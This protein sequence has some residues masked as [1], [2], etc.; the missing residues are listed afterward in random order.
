MLTVFFSDFCFFMDI[1]SDAYVGSIFR[2]ALKELK[3][4]HSVDDDVD[5]ED[6]D[7]DMDDDDMCDDDM[8]GA[9]I[10]GDDMGGGGMD[11]GV[12]DDVKEGNDNMG[13][14]QMARIL[15]AFGA[16]NTVVLHEYLNFIQ[17]TTDPYGSYS[18]IGGCT[19][20][21]PLLWVALA[22][23]QFPRR[24]THQ[25]FLNEMVYS[26]VESCVD[27]KYSAYRVQP[28]GLDWKKADTDI[29]ARTKKTGRKGHTRKNPRKTRK[30]SAT[31][32]P[33]NQLTPM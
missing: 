17:I 5:G 27:R 9:D 14:G 10:H 20:V 24:F 22:N 11:D 30:Q 7:E 18:L 12:D 29:S 6:L 21:I 31:K 16:R 8:D 33:R 15:D 25:K 28:M 32:M 13:G 26:A 1:F 23:V 2:V 3:D 4:L 19:S